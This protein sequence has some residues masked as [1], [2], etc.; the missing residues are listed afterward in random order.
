MIARLCQCFTAR[1]HNVRWSADALFQDALSTL[2]DLFE[3]HPDLRYRRRLAEGEGILC[4]NVPHRRDAF[5]DG[6]KSQS[7]RLMYRGRFTESLKGTG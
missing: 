4:A 7:K 3:N 5:E 1:K 6:D 2:K